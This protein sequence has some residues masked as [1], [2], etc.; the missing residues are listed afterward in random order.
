MIGDRSHDV[1]GAKKA[2]LNSIGVL[3]GYGCKEELEKAG[4][5]ELAALPSDVVEIVLGKEIC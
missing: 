3:Y 2:G 5:G 4:A 1:T